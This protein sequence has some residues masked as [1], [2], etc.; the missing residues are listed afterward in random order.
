MDKLKAGE[1]VYTI[2]NHVSKSGM[3]RVIDLV[4][5]RDNQ[6]S[7]IYPFIRE[8]EEK[9]TK[10]FKPDKKHQGFR[11]SGVGMDMGFNL[12]YNLSSRLFPNGFECIGWDKPSKDRCPSSDHVNNPKV[13]SE[14]G[15]IHKDGG[16]AL[17]QKWL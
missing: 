13:N 7:N 3:L 1:T 2:L 4:V 5:I 9:F 14:D 6:P 11:V 10:D 8:I 12:V 16:Y 17:K 15:F